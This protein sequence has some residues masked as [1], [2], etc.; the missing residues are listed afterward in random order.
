MLLIGLPSANRA[1]SN[2]Q[3]APKGCVIKRDFRGTRK[4]CSYF[5]IFPR[6]VYHAEL[7]TW[8]NSR[9]ILISTGLN[10]LS[11]KIFVLIH[12]YTFEN[13]HQCFS[14]F[15]P[16]FKCVK[17]LYERHI[18]KSHYLPLFRSNHSPSSSI[19]YQIIFS[20]SPHSSTYKL[21]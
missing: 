13:H 21:R 7:K 9:K 15:K 12:D 20:T 16:I 2:L 19:S 18:S 8:T 10:L 3:R 4:F 6:K 17:Y 14:L 1:S 11:L 5:D